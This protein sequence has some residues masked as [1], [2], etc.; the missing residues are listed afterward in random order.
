MPRNE[1]HYV[2]REQAEVKHTVLEAYLETLFMVIAHKEHTINYVDCFSGPWSEESATLEDTSI[3][4]S[5]NAMAKTINTHKKLFDRNIKFRA[6]YIEEN[7]EAYSKLE[8]HLK[9]NKNPTI[10]TYS[11]HGDFKK[12][13]NKL[14]DWT[15]ASFTFFFIDPKGWKEVISAETLSPLLALKKSEFLINFM[16]DFV[17]RFVG[18]DS[19]KHQVESLFGSCPKFIGNETPE[20][21]QTI[22]LDMYQR[23]VNKVFDGKATFVPVEKPGQDKVLYFLVYLTR[24]AIGVAKFKTAAEKMV[25]YQRKKQSGRKLHAQQV[26][27]PVYDLFA[28]DVQGLDVK[29]IKDNRLAAREYLLSHLSKSPTLIDHECWA[30]F[31]IDSQLYPT[32]FQLAMKE[33]VKEGK[34]EN[35]TNNV[36]R[37]RSKVIKPDWPNKSE[38]WKL[39]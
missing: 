11:I 1:D 29:N 38:E 34:V 2:G 10:E 33:L 20:Q 17:N 21:R 6:M 31:L 15:Q 4:I 30:K 22:L 7:N 12:Q 9:I 35:V 14:V 36:S 39:G 23:H 13:V 27:S 3:G 18:M 24:H 19:L 8:K 28:D 5:L 16:Y 25:V 32:D 26:K 37:R